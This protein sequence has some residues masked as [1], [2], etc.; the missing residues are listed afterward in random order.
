MPTFTEIPKEPEAFHPVSSDSSSTFYQGSQTGRRN[1]LNLYLYLLNRRIREEAIELKNL[2]EEDIHLIEEILQQIIKLVE[3]PLQTV[4]LN[5][6]PQKLEEL[7][8]QHQFRAKNQFCFSLLTPREKE[9]LAKLATG[10]SNKEVADL[11]FISLDTVKHHRKL[12]KSK[13]LASST[14][15]FIKYAQAFDL[16]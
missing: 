3:S 5:E 11:L 4:S 16:K 12:I 1:A 8:V 9:V 10:I 6:I 13:L 14:A 7:H 15:D 2:Y